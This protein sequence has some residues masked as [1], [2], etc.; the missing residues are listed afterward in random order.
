MLQDLQQRADVVDGGHRQ[1]P[2]DTV[3]KGRC[4]LCLSAVSKKKSVTTRVRCKVDVFAE[5]WPTLPM[6]IIARVG[7]P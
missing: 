7:K 6:R 1:L 5:P 3:S 2:P 4:A